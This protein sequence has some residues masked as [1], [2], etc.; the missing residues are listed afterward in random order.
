MTN[1]VEW[2]RQRAE[3]DLSFFIKL[4][5]PHQVLGGVHEELIQWWNRPEAKSHQLVL[6]PRDHGKSRMI[7]YRVAWE[8]TKNPALTVL[9]ISATSNLAEKQLYFI[10]NILTSKIYRQFW[11]EM[12]NLEE[13]KRERWTTGE[14]SVDHPLRKAE[15]VRDPTIFSAGLTTTITGLH[16]D[17][18]VLDDVVVRENAYTGEGRDK[19]TAAYSLLASIATGDSK[20]WSVGTRYHP[21]DLYDTLLEIEED[22]YD[23]HGDHAGTVPVYELFEKKVEDRGD[24]TGE[25]CWPK[26]Q[27][28]DGK[29][30]GFDAAILAR[31]RAKYLDKT[32]FYA[33]YYNN[34]NAPGEEKIG[35]D[36]ILYYDKKFVANKNGTWFFKD[37]KLNVYA[38][39][40]FA[41]SRGKKADYT[42]IVVIGIDPD[43]NVYVLDIDRARTD[44]L[45]DYFEMILNMYMKWNFKKLRAEANV[46]QAVI[47]QELKNNYIKPN[48]L[49][50]F[51]DEHKPSRHEGNKQE[52][53]GAVLEPRYAN[54]QMYHYMGGNCQMLEEELTMAHPPHDDMIDALASAIQIAVPPTRARIK[55]G[56][57][58]LSFNSRFGGV[59]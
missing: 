41:Y 19:V 1:K 28:P 46:A 42:A 35:K 12:V 6:L 7:A 50:L 10:K 26:Q 53:V 45:S 3:S 30:F 13:S 11:P 48:G 23:E 39:I 15:G 38:A 33:Q 58:R 37:N 31:K 9:Y 57:P 21:K 36:K 47:V 5:A 24:G 8:I 16:F 4:I 25:F 59:A 2:L 27:R 32:Q 44:K 56:K 51:I 14:I 52:R 43:S 54:G 55:E 40:D 49:S 17:I 20:E 18:V 22:I 34:P 29:W